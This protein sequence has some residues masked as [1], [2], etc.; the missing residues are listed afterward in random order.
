[1]PKGRGCH[2][3]I[4]FKGHWLIYERGVGGVDK[5]SLAMCISSGIAFA[6]GIG[7]DNPLADHKCIMKGIHVSLID[8]FMTMEQH[9]TTIVS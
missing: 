5:C 1:M 6:K 7:A 9:N 2:D 8:I 3:R 4:S